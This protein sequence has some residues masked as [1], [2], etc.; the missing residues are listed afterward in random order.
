MGSLTFDVR[1]AVRALLRTP[2][3]TVV[4][5][6]TLALGIGANSAIFSLVNAVLIRPLGYAEPDRLM[7][8]YEGIPEADIPR[9]GV[10]PPDF[11]DLVQYQR[12]FTQ[13]GAYRTR[14]IEMS[15]HGEPEQITVA[16]VTAEVL[17]ILGINASSGRA[18]LASDGENPQVAVL[19][20]GL[21]QRR[22]GGGSVVGERLILDRQPYQIVGVMPAS[23]QFPKRGPALNGEPADAWIP[24]VFNPFE[25]QARGMFYNHSVVGRLRDGV[26]AE[27]AAADTSAL[28]SRIRENYPAILRNGPFSLVVNAVPMM[29][30]IAG[31]VQRPLLLLLGAVGLV[32]L[33]ACANVANLILSRAVVREREIGLRTALGAARY[34]LFQM[35]LTES[36]LLAAAAGA[37]GLLIGHWIVRAM[38][39][40]IA[41]SLPGVSD[42]T[43]DGRVV[44]FTLALSVFT[45]VVFGLV[46][47]LASGRQDL[48]DLLREG[49]TRA[50]AGSRQHRMQAS[51]VVTSVAF[52]FVL[53]VGAGFSSAASTTCSP[54]TLGWRSPT[55]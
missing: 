11:N 7:L 8:V 50:T 48:N 24:L 53:L 54:S 15:G 4:T 39:A 34:R 20:H 12:S 5:V 49:A 23:F 43:L 17:P 55:C 51:L 18:L 52:A 30:D 35:L 9:F 47:M 28:A 26:S 45:A 32:L 16:Q 1:H 2:V 44:G 33:V 21:W 37:L 40:V 19:S 29:D 42:V 13:I 41:T 3:F 22:F 38:P 10:S 6:M 14:S 25:R 31:Q 46:P 36:L 27:Q